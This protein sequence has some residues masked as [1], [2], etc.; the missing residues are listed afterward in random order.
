MPSKKESQSISILDTQTRLIEAK[1]LFEKDLI[2]KG[3]Y[4]A[5]RKNTRFG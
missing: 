1:K 4:E 2:S 5:I 3:E